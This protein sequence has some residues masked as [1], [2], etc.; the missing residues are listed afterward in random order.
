MPHLPSTANLPAFPGQ[1]R[2]DQQWYLMLSERQYLIAQ[3]P[4]FAEQLKA[5]DQLKEEALYNLRTEYLDYLISPDSDETKRK[6]VQ[7]IRSYLEKRQHFLY[8]W[9]SKQAWEEVNQMWKLAWEK[10]HSKS[11]VTAKPVSSVAVQHALEG[12][13]N[14]AIPAITQAPPPTEDNT[15]LSLDSSPPPSGLDNSVDFVT[16]TDN[17]AAPLVSPP[18]LEEFWGNSSVSC[19]TPATTEDVTPQDVESAAA[20]LSAEPDTAAQ[21]GEETVKPLEAEPATADTAAQP[22]E[23][24]V[25]P[26]EA[27]PATADTAAQP[28]EETVKPLGA[29]PATADAAAQPG[30]ETVEPQDAEP[31]STGP[32]ALPG[33]E[34]YAPQQVE[35]APT[36]KSTQAEDPTPPLVDF[37]S[38]PAESGE[39]LS[40]AQTEGVCSV[41]SPTSTVPVMEEIGGLLRKSRSP[42]RAVKR[43]REKRSR[44]PTPGRF[45]TPLALKVS[46]RVLSCNPKQ[47][48]SSQFS[49][50]V[51]PTLV[52]PPPS[53]TCK[54]RTHTSS[55]E[56]ARAL[57]RHQKCS[58]SSDGLHAY[59]Q[60][61]A[62][63]PR[64]G[65]KAKTGID[66]WTEMRRAWLRGIHVRK[67]QDDRMPPVIPVC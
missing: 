58:E 49:T 51:S 67:K 6:I 15:A 11:G 18:S 9:R 44:K 54:L 64:E 41:D 19:I 5:M 17:V 42:I 39:P 12:A 8:L 20:V 35:S 4:K 28:G 61:S 2:L 53:H 22:G 52:S 3:C 14:G 63:L 50:T 30:E 43:P 38:P 60:R 24:T 62:Q 23:E 48:E 46:A 36:E 33:G 37:S 66:P 10:H 27:E 56:S 1:S 26:L 34:V 40:A 57:F 59:E 29:E 55:R 21:P 16:S 65:T 7:G 32:S 25:K 47:D 31:A 13:V 45:T